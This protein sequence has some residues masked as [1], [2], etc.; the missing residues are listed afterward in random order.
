MKIPSAALDLLQRA[1]G[2]SDYNTPLTG[3][4]AYLELLLA[5][6]SFV[7]DIKGGTQ[8]EGV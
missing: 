6:L 3:I 8:T 7:S 1:N 4:E 5:E 2:G